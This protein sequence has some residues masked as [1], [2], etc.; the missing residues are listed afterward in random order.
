VKK[1][2]CELRKIVKTIR[3]PKDLINEINSIS[4]AQKTNFTEFVKTAIESYI[5]GL[6]FTDA[7][8]ES[9]GAWDHKK[10]PELKEGAENYIRKV[11]KGRKPNGSF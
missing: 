11:R 5:R 1:E 8:N 10:H 7:V 6:K 9:A 2:V 3:F 4:A